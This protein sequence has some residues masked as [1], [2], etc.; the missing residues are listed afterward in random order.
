ML[1][2]V[3]II[4][5]AAEVAQFLV[6]QSLALAMLAWN[7]DIPDMMAN[8]TGSNRLLVGVGWL[9][10]FFTAAYFYKNHTGKLLREMRLDDDHS[11]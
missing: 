7:Q 10:I 6:S 2:S 1:G 9:L 11:V 5:W 8:F 3:I 4:A